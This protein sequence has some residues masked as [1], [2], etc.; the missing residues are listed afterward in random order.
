[1]PKGLFGRRYISQ[2]PI[3][4]QL[5]DPFGHDRTPNENPNSISMGAPGFQ[6]AYS[7]PTYADDIAASGVQRQLFSGLQT[8]AEPQPEVNGMGGPLLNAHDI[9]PNAPQG[10]SQEQQNAQAARDAIARARSMHGEPVLDPNSNPTWYSQRQ[11]LDR[12]REQAAADQAEQAHRERV[13]F[14]QFWRFGGRQ[15]PEWQYGRDPFYRAPLPQQ[16][17]PPRR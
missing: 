8:Q 7:P 10:L 2:H 12:L 13:S 1:M 11:E 6:N 14:E 9:I 4:A 3:I 16:R 15:S 5:M 17:R